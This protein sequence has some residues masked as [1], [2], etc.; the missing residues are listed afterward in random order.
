MESEAHPMA[1]KAKTKAMVTYGAVG[2]ALLGLF[3]LGWKYRD[4]IP[5]IRRVFAG[6]PALPVE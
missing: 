6:T 2:A 1:M 5:G 3:A 4:R